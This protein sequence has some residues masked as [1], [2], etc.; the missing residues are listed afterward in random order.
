MTSPF[1]GMDPYLEDPALWPGPHDQL[2]YNITQAL[3]KA[4]PEGYAA[5][6]QHR[7]YIANSQRQF[8][9]DVVTLQ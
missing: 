6:L 1:P 2:I 4:L 3:N 7:L 8:I 5:V 9:T